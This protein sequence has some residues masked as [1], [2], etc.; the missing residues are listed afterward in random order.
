MQVLEWYIQSFIVRIWLE[1]EPPGNR[2]GV[3]RGQIIHVPSG[4]QQ[5]FQELSQ[6]E[7]FIIPFLEEM[8]ARVDG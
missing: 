2:G 4:K 7:K 5:Y 6:V 8:G 1:E 3:W